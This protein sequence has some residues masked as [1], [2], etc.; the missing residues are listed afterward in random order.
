LWVWYPFPPYGEVNLGGVFGGN[1]FKG[2]LNEG[3]FGD[4]PGLGR[5]LKFTFTLYDSKGILP[6]GR[7]FTHIVYLDN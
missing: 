5:A 1:D 6:K 4:I 7:V 2:D 3:D